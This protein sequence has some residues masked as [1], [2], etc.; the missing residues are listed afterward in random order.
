MCGGCPWDVDDDAIRKMFEAHGAVMKAQV[1]F[2][3]GVVYICYCKC[4]CHVTSLP[5]MSVSTVT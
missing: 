1:S 3:E 5:T 2:Y 4:C